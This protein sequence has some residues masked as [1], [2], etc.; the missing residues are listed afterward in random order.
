[1]DTSGVDNSDDDVRERILHG[2]LSLYLRVRSH[3]LA[4]DIVSKN[5]LSLK[6]KCSKALRKEIKNSTEK[7]QINTYSL[8]LGWRL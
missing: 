7:P 8:A 5:K 4:R 1:M 3:S 6:K 2:M